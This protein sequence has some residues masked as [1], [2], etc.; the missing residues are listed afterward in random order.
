MLLLLSIL[1]SYIH[2]VLR[3]ATRSSS[4][5]TSWIRSMYVLPLLFIDL[6]FGLTIIQEMIIGGGMAFTFK[7]YIDNVKVLLFRHLSYDQR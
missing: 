5:R 7:H 1:S 6:A 2:A 3:S 4:S